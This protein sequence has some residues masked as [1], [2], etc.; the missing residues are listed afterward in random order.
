MEDN[1]K[2]VC[3]NLR[4]GGQAVMEGVMM[5]GKDKY[6]VSVRKPDQTIITALF[7]C[8]SIKEKYKFLKLPILRG[9]VSFVESMS[10]G[11]K[12]L[13]YSSEFFLEEEETAKKPKKESGLGKWW[14]DHQ[15]DI[16]MGFSVVLGVVLALGLFIL[17]PAVLT[18]WLD[19]FINSRIVLSLCEGAVRVALFIGY[20]LAISQMKDIQR[21]F[22]YHGAEHKTINC[23]EDGKSLSVENVLPYTRLNRR[24]GTSFMFLVMFISILFFAVIYVSNP[25]LK[26]VYRLLLIPVVAGVSYE[27]LMFSNKSDSAFMKIVSWPGMMMQKLTTREADGSQVE[28]AIASTLVVLK[29]EGRLP[30]HLEADWERVRSQITLV[31]GE[32]NPIEV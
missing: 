13:T 7:E 2:V 28:T 31:D 11:M 9:V 1:K 12:T 30:E 18:L 15:E 6:A 24:C 16:L 26:L 4:V 21:V 3:S 20:I 25:L 32:G 10:I 8:T 22:E 17:L 29:A 27:V 19:N 23:M 14:Q 5:K